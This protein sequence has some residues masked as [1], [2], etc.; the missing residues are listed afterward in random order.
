M[1]D[2]PSSCR[3]AILAR[4]KECGPRPGKSQPSDAAARFRACRTPESHSGRPLPSVRVKTHFSGCARSAA[5][6]EAVAFNEVSQRKR[7]LP[8]LRFRIVYVIAPVALHDAADA[9]LQDPHVAQFRTSVGRK[10]GNSGG[11]EGFETFGG[12]GEIRTHD[13]FH[14][15]EARSQLPH[16]PGS[17]SFEYTTAHARFDMPLARLPTMV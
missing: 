5:A 6:L 15:M 13:L 2:A 3:H 11:G 9:T 4:R 16:R 10:T 14:A 1:L 17:V 12:P 7:A 8:G